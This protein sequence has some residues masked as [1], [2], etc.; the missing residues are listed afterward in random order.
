MLLVEMMRNFQRY[1]WCINYVIE[2]EIYR[3]IHKC[4]MKIGAY[5]LVQI[6]GVCVGFLMAESKDITNQVFML[7][8]G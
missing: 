2:V 8:K 4:V 6:N 1:R 7:L 5:H 3:I